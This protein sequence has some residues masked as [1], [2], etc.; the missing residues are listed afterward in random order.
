MSRS[1]FPSFPSSWETCFLKKMRDPNWCKLPTAAWSFLSGKMKT[2]RSPDLITLSSALKGSILQCIYSSSLEGTKRM[3]AEAKHTVN[4]T[5]N[6]NPSFSRT[7]I[8]VKTWAAVKVSTRWFHIRERKGKKW[9]H[10]GDSGFRRNAHFF[11]LKSSSSSS[12]VI[13]IR[14]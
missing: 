2:A 7:C 6:I 1:G 14:P 9:V 4:Q 10:P 11:N 13:I 3:D 12:L 8:P 5:E